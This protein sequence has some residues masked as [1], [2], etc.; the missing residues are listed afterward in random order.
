MRSVDHQSNGLYRRS[1]GTGLE[2]SG[3]LLRVQG[4]GAFLGKE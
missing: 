2:G 1:R 4:V 3:D